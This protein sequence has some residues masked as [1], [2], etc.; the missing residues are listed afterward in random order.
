MLWHRL[1]LVQ[2]ISNVKQFH[3]LKTTLARGAKDFGF[4]A[5]SL[6]V[7]S[8]KVAR[9]IAY[10]L[11]VDYQREKAGKG[12]RKKG[13]TMEMNILIRDLGKAVYLKMLTA[14]K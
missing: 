13:F 4:A 7:G 6:A 10:C 3:Y 9:V 1:L 5:M 14:S 12:K 11:P 8:M 2:L